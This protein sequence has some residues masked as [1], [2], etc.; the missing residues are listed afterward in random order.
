MASLVKG[1]LAPQELAPQE[2]DMGLSIINMNPID[3]VE[4]LG[5]YQFI[6][7]YNAVPMPI[8]NMANYSTNL[9]NQQFS[10]QVAIPQPVTISNVLSDA[11]KQVAQNVKGFGN[12]FNSPQPVSVNTN[13]Q[14]GVFSKGD[15]VNVIRFEGSNAIIE[16]PNYVALETTNVKPSWISLLNQNVINKSEF[17]IPKEYLMKVKDNFP[18]T[19][20]TGINFGANLK[21]QPVYNPVKPIYDTTLEQ[22][23]TFVLTK[24][25]DYISGYIPRVCPPNE[26]CKGGMV[27]QYSVLKSGTKVSGRLYSKYIQAFGG[28]M[29][30]TDRPDIQQNV[31]KVE[32]YGSQGSI[33]IPI[34]YLTRFL[35]TVVSLVDKKI[36]KCNETGLIQT[37]DYNP[38]RVSAVKGETYKG[39]ISGGSFHTTDGKTFIPINEYKIIEEN[40]GAVVPVAN[41]NNNLFLI[42]GAFILG[43]ALFSNDKSE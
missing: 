14:V 24:D 8:M 35:V 27:E 2:L 3:V 32:G 26:L 19:I 4:K 30:S 7:D 31:L 16:N 23:A 6:Y 13:P 21:P 5:K 22:N 1:E 12:T 11:I 36:G 17:M 39:Y 18:V 43:Y 40:S 34:D 15:I 29:A 10:N 20:Q 41:N 38:C 33:E 9:E 28:G 37:M 42:A 25:F